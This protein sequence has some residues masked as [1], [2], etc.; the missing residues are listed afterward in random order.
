MP[1]VVA[2]RPRVKAAIRR[3]SKGVTFMLERDSSDVSPM[4][5]SSVQPRVFLQP[6]AAPSILGLYG[7]AASTF[8]VAAQMAHWF[9][10]AETTMYFVPFAA[11][12][13]G[14]A[15]FLAGMW[16]FKA[17]DGV[18]TAIHGMWGSFWMA[19]GVLAGI[20]ARSGAGAAGAMF[21]SL[22]YWFIVLAAITWVCMFAASAES[23][24]MAVV[25]ALLAAGSTISAVG[26]LSGSGGLMELAGYLFVGCALAAWYCGSALMLREA[27]GR[28]VWGIGRSARIV[29]SASVLVGPEPGVIH[30]QA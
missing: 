29:R 26:L 19:F 12:F 23:M 9:G 6:I 20:Y 8:I 25:C 27:F 10:T 22:G 5:Y 24:S 15:Q 17:R 4:D 11:I 13:G 7:L 1:H 2:L 16:A 30:G 21:P 18:A 28:E 14:L 3:L